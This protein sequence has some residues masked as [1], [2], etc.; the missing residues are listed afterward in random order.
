MGK[1]EVKGAMDDAKMGL[2]MVRKGRINILP[3][4]IRGKKAV[5]E[6]FDRVAAAHKK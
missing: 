2:D 4:N 1:M 3:H 5:K 6:I